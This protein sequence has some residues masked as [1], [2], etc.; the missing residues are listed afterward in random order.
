MTKELGQRTTET[1][2]TSKG[3]YWPIALAAALT[4][5]VVG[6]VVHPAISLVGIALCLVAMLAWHAQSFHGPSELEAIPDEVLRLPALRTDGAKASVL[7]EAGARSGRWG[8]V[9]FI[10]SEAVFFGNLIA[11][12][13]Y[14]RVRSESSP[15]VLQ[16]LDLLFPGI[17]TVILLSSS[18]PAYYAHRAIKRDDRRGLQ[19][20]LAFA[21]LLGA[22]FLAGQGYE[23]ATAGLT[24]QTDIF[25]A[26][27]FV[28]TGFHGAHV[29]VGIGL[30]LA[31]LALSARG[32]FSAERNFAVEVASTYWHF[33]DVV[34]VFLFTTLYL[35]R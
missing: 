24:L 32:R 9:W 15:Q 12:Y 19:I 30:L 17:N 11:A 13:L 29:V 21:A 22:I 16:H 1:V 8:L 10:A 14:L 18:I 35:I 31:V 28:L 4:L 23:Y 6:L 34:W 3:S 20:G 26:G 27:F 7:G 5:A 2:H 33:V 25:A